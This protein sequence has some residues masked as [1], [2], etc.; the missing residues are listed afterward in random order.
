MSKVQRYNSA[1]LLWGRGILVSLSIFM[2]GYNLG[3]VNTLGARLVM[4]FNWTDQQ[5]TTN[6]SLVSSMLTL[7]II[8][9]PILSID[10]MRKLGRF[11][12]I[13]LI[14]VVSDLGLI[15]CCVVNFPVLLFGRFLIGMAVG[16]AYSAAPLYIGELTP[17][18]KR[19]T[20]TSI[21]GIALTLGLLVSFL[22]GLND[23][24]N[25][26]ND[27]VSWRVA[28]FIPL[29]VNM[30]QIVVMPWLLVESPRFYIM[31]KNDEE[32]AM[33]N[34]QK[35]F[36]EDFVQEELESLK[37]EKM[38]LQPNVKVFAFLREYWR[39]LLVAIDVAMINQLSGISPL[40]FF[41]NQLFL[42]SGLS[43]AQAQLYT[44]I[45][46]I[47]NIL[48][49][50]TTFYLVKKF[51]PKKICMI[52]L[53]LLIIN[54]VAIAVT[55]MLDAW[56]ITRYLLI[57]F[58]FVFSAS[59][60]STVFILIPSLVP[61]MGCN[62]AFCFNGI[63]SFVIGY[64]FLYIKDSSIGPSGAFLIY[65][66]F[67]A[68]SILHLTFELPETQGKTLDEVMLFFL[69]SPAPAKKA[70]SEP[71]PAPVII[72]IGPQIFEPITTFGI[73]ALE[74]QM[75]EPFAALVEIRMEPNLPQSEYAKPV[76]PVAAEG[77]WLKMAVL[78]SPP[79]AVK[80]QSCEDE[81]ES[82]SKNMKFEGAMAPQVDQSSETGSQSNNE[83]MK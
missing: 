38:A 5:Q 51:T 60:G 83:E 25:D 36:K 49:S 71:M 74:D 78:A 48:G 10:V 26:P 58:C 80:T 65:A 34:L 17:M 62:I 22:V 70:V 27:N 37:K 41:S 16:L 56:V 20:L 24:I 40:N 23:G 68:M 12:A 63:A 46:G 54:L 19:S 72:S 73:L 47:I 29:L 57:I 45:T 76:I 21:P 33:K 39:P 81:M 55:I 77:A 28:F 32:A 13:L 30:V 15:L 64:T 52:G 61:A 31:S 4:N 82:C 35:I 50:F 67:C 7:A 44:I 53:Y 18:E 14:N 9:G 69:K 1:S 59:L 2:A 3:I 11:K 6:L 43:M 8:F 66:G 75:P 42:K 79:R